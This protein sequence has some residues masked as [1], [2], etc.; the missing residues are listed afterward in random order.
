MRTDGEQAGDQ[1]PVPRHL[2]T[3]LL[4][5]IQSLEEMKVM[6]RVVFAGAER[7]TPAVP[8]DELLRPEA[9]RWISSSDSPV[10]ATTRV[11]RAVEQAVA[12]GALLRLTVRSA[13]RSDDYLLPGTP[14]SR[15]LVERLAHDN[16]AASA[17]RL[18]QNLDA[19]L[20]RPN[21]FAFYEQHVGPLTPLVAEHLREAE[22]SYPRA[23]I[24]GAVLEAVRHQR[25][26]WRYIESILH[27]WE[28]RGAPGPAVE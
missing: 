21:V 4:P 22:R 26:S 10:P 20:Y 19:V 13:G 7:G 6:L 16:A 25:R 15:D 18:P 11:R 23:W 8:M 2:F 12:D 17:L 3:H 24:E 9:V 27:D 1:L 5:R 28:R 14:A